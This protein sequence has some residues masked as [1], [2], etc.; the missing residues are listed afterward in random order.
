MLYYTYLHRRA[1]DSQPFYVGK[2]KGCRLNSRR[3]R[4]PFWRH[5]A[6]KHGV[7]AELIAYWPTEAEAFEHE[8]FLIWCFRDMGITLCN[9]TDGGEGMSGWTPTEETRQK[10]SE[11]RIGQGNHRFGKSGILSK[12]YGRHLSDEHKGKLSLAFA[13]DKNHMYGKARTQEVKDKISQKKLG[14][15]LPSRQVR[16]LC[17]ESGIEFPSLKQAALWATGIETK[18]PNIVRSA[19][20]DGRKIAY[21]Y[22]WKYI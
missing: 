13:G 6:N 15:P 16:I 19:K 3:D 1:S 9:L 14:V 2:G 17:I 18:H 22:R 10:W 21:G 8:K 12:L 11:Q 5:I 7:T 4:S 20:S